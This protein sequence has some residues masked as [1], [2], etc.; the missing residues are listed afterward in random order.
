MGTDV[1][2]HVDDIQHWAFSSNVGENLRDDRSLGPILEETN[3]QCKKCLMLM[4]MSSVSM[5]MTAS[6]SCFMSVSMFISLEQPKYC[7]KSPN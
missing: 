3:I 5:S 1:E 2:N 7:N 6:T 4:S